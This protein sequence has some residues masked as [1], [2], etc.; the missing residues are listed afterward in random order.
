MTSPNNYDAPYGLPVSF[1]G[2]IGLL[3]LGGSLSIP[4]LAAVNQ[5]VA[6]EIGPLSAGELVGLLFFVVWWLVI[7][8]PWSPFSV[9]DPER[10]VDQ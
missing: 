9:V 1:C 5:F 7:L 2:W 6:F 3:V 8:G 10:E 4:I